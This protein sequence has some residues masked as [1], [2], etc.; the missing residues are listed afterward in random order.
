MRFQYI[1]GIAQIGPQLQVASTDSEVHS[2]EALSPSAVLTS[3]LKAPSV[4]STHAV[5]VAEQTKHAS[6]MMMS[7]IYFLRLPRAAI[8]LCESCSRPEQPSSMAPASAPSRLKHCLK[9]AGDHTYV[10]AREQLHTW[11]TSTPEIPPAAP[12]S[13]AALSKGVVQN[14]PRKKLLRCTRMIG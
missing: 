11:Q 5:G 13:S 4:Q 2:K 10:R 3:T 14:P 8:T 12:V 1:V 6:G 9:R 7:A